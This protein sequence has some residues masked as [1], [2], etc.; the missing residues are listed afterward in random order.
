MTQTTVQAQQ[1]HALDDQALLARLQRVL[2]VEAKAVSALAHSLDASAAE[3][4][5]LIFQAKGRLVLTGMGKSGHIAKKVAA[6]FS[7]TGTPAFFVH[8]AEAQHG[9]L[10]MIQPEDL[11]LAFSYSGETD[12]LRFIAPHLKRMGTRMV[13]VTGNPDSSLAQLADVHLLAAVEEEACPLNLA[14]TASTTAALAL[15]DALAVAVL[16]LRGFSHE[17]FARSHPGGALGR[18]LLVRVRDVM[19]TADDVPRVAST[20]SLA[21][22]LME[23]SAKRMGMTSVVDEDGRALGIFTDGDLRRFLAQG[24]G[25]TDQPVTHAM[26]RGALTISAEA[27]AT[28]AA[29]TME[30]R[31]LNHLLVLDD[32]GHLVGAVGIHDLLEA[33]IL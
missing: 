15:G 32:S 7:S 22:A 26:T 27:L 4:V 30:S 19:R 10:G 21:D 28:E 14:P 33:K 16:E 17:D 9:D 25:R 11:V 13:A 23:M 31:R 18:R 6:T 12:E 24:S 3:A 5:R 1:T 8:P 29:H 20:A 2:H